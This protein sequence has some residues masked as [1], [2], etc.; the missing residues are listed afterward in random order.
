MLIFHTWRRNTRFRH[1]RSHSRFEFGVPDRCPKCASYKLVT[2]S[3][4]D[5][6]GNA[7]H[8][9]MCDACGW[10]SRAHGR[11]ATVS[12]PP[13]KRTRRTKEDGGPCVFVEVPLRGPQPPK[14]T[15]ANIA[16][17]RIKHRLTGRSRPTRR[18]RA[19]HRP[20]ARHRKEAASRRFAISGCSVWGEA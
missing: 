4:P 1:G 6:S 12:G 19:A 20:S 18:E 16:R 17:C 7:R 5:K 3:R 15:H 13:P 10:K 9:T 8:F 11:V 14:P 2:Y